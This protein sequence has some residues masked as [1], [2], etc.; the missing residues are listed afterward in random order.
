[1]TPT[2]RVSTPPNLQ[3]LLPQSEEFSR[4]KEVFVDP[5][6]NPNAIPYLVRDILNNLGVDTMREGLSDTPTRVRDSLLFLTSGYRTKVEELYK[7]F[8]DGAAG[9]E[10]MVVQTNIPF[11]SMCEHHLLPFLGVAHVAYIPSGRIVGL[12]KIARVVEAYAR[13]LQVQERM[14]A[15]IADS[16]VT[17]LE[18]RG[19]GVVLRARHLCMEARGVR[20]QGTMTTTSAL[21]GIML[22]PEV[23]Q[24]FMT[25]VSIAE[26][27]SRPL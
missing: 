2:G 15:E 19:V 10:E 17:H 22:N 1:M 13:R 4:I 23:R 20:S 21:R 26:N 9:A 7:T 24:E 12:S 25:F 16:M 5:D 14:T 27:N 8:E 18:P 11:Y 3:Q 6:P